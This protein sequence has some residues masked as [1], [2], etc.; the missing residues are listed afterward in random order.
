MRCNTVLAT[1]SCFRDDQ[2]LGGPRRRRER[3]NPCTIRSVLGVRLELTVTLVACQ[4]G[5]TALI[6]AAS[7]SNLAAVA[8]LVEH[9]ANVN[10]K[11]MV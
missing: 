4:G 10:V 5:E 7:C 11:E 9:G 3:Q 6:N 2:V 8:H 1:T